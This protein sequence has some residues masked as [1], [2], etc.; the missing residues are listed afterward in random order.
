LLLREIVWTGESAD[1]RD[2]VEIGTELRAPGTVVVPHAD[3][4]LRTTAERFVNEL[5]A[6]RATGAVVAAGRYGDKW[7]SWAK[8]R[9][10]EDRDGDTFEASDCPGP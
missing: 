1:T 8:P 3:G 10:G 4:A 7:P 5:L 6:G 9:G 2:L